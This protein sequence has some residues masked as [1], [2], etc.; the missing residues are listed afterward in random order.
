MLILAIDPGTTQSAFC[1]MRTEDQSCVQFGIRANAELPGTVLE[2]YPVGRVVIEMVASYGMPVGREVFETC[3]WIGR[4]AQIAE[5]WY[6]PVDF[7]YRRDVKLHLCGSAQANDANIRHALID[8]FAVHD[9]KNGKGTKKNPDW[10][11][12]FAKDVWAA[13][14]VGV[15]YIDRKDE[16]HG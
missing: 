15:T 11:Y 16:K 1:L 9:L 5:D 12:G 4:F 6:M 3:V 10:F 7:V 14:A 13:Y 8:R 2:E